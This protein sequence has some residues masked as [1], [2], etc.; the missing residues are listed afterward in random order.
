[1]PTEAGGRRAWGERRDCKNTPHPTAPMWRWS[2]GTAGSG[3][4]EERKEQRNNMP[5]T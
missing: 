2:L 1:M 5:V 4:A 3:E